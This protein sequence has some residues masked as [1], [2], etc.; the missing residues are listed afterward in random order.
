MIKISVIIPVF[1]VE[2]YLRQCLDSV[3]AQ[4]L[5]EIEVICIDDGS[6]DHS[7][8][9]LLEYQK[10]YEN[11]IALRQR[12]QG[13]GPA[14]NYGISKA[15]GKYLGFMDPDDY[16]A[17]ECAL[18]KLYLAAE[19]NH[20]SI[21]GGNMLLESVHGDRTR[22]DKW[23]YDN[24]LTEFKD[25]GFFYSFQRYIYSSELI[26][27]NSIVFPP[28]RRFQ[29][30]P[31]LMKA[32]ICAQRFYALRENIYIHR[33]DY[34]EVDHTLKVAVDILC[35]IR[36]V[37][38]MAWKYDLRI[39]YESELK[40]ALYARLKVFYQYAVQDRKEVWDLIGQ[41]RA[42][43]YNWMG[44][45]AEEFKDIDHLKE[46]IAQQREA[47][48]NM[49]SDCRNASQVVIYGA[50]RYGRYFLRNWGK[51][52]RNII[53]FAVDKK[54]DNEEFIEGYAVREITEYNKNTLIIVAVSK[55]NADGVL[56]NLSG[57]QFKKVYYIE[58]VAL[59]LLEEESDDHG[60]NK[61]WKKFQS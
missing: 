33:V 40:Y 42:I 12:N 4:T 50:G 28:Y 61:V 20:M 15:A 18:E 9:I 45:A 21:C 38:E 3:L 43:Q 30:P 52:C 37:Y 27:Q 46:Y 8:D 44:E 34:K 1:N 10:K 54:E 60:E 35:G 14:R 48:D 17:Q 53:G 58:Y 57:L 36:D 23:F 29:D 2:A 39:I 5:K 25:F 24:R 56:R 31:F 19:E 11:V 6:E 7:Y 55:P 16:Y 26:R 51:K 22:H 13:A 59:A 47:K 32:M 49:L 41:I